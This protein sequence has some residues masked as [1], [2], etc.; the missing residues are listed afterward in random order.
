MDPPL[1]LR[2]ELACRGLDQQ[3]ADLSRQVSTLLGQI[4]RLQHGSS[5]A[6][7]AAPNLER[8]LVPTGAG[9][10]ATT[11]DVITQHMVTFQDIEVGLKM[12][13]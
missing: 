3:V 11:D 13:S 5:A 7:S 8:Q 9:G 1:H 4:Q 6:E 12:G 2:L 10:A